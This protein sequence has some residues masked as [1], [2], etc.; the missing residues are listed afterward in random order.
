MSRWQEKRTTY[1]RSVRKKRGTDFSERSVKN[2]QSVKMPSFPNKRKD[3]L[4][5]RVFFRNKYLTKNKHKKEKKQL[6]SF[7]AS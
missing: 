1:F 3:F 7:N 5:C 4:E 6:A 2:E